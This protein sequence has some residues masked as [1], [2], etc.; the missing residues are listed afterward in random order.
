MRLNQTGIHQLL[1]VAGAG[2]LAAMLAA[3]SNAT[4]VPQLPIAVALA[5]FSVTPTSTSAKAGSVTFAVTNVA[6]DVAHEF[7]VI[8]TDLAADQL[9]VGGDQKVDE[10][11]VTVA[12]ELPEMTMGSASTL[13][14]TLEAGHYVL[15]C[16]VVGHYSAGMRTDFTVNP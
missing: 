9:P 11:A 4:A 1:R 6:T 15:I 12:G 10:T 13:N 16:N 14:V 7:V 2:F 8:K 3:C 5:S